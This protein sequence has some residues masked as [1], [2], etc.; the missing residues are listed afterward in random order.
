[1]IKEANRKRQTVITGIGIVS[2]LGIGL[3]DFEQALMSGKSGVKKLELLN[4]PAAP[5]SCG[6][7]VSAFIEKEARKT[8]LK[9]V[10]KSIK[11]MCR[12]IQLGVASALQAVGQSGLDLDKIES[13]RFG[14]DFGANLM[15]SPPQ[16]L[17]DS[18][19]ASSEEGNFV[20][21]NWGTIGLD[22]MEPLWLLCYL[23][24][25]PAC[26]IGISMD[27]QGPSN[28]IT[29]D[30]ASGYLVM[31]EAISIIDRDWADIM[32]AGATGTRLHI[33]KAIHG[34]FW[35][36]L[37]ESD[38]DPSTWSRP[39]DANRN[40]QV[41]AEGGASFILEEE[42]HAKARNAQTWGK[43]LGRGASCVNNVPTQGRY[44]ESLAAAMRAALR[45]AGL[46]PEEI[47][48]I[49]AHGLGEREADEGE[50]QAIHDV[51]GEHASTVPVTSMKS[52]WGNAGPAA[53]TLE[54]AASLVSLKHGVILPTLNYETP[55]TEKPLNVVHGEPLA[56]E[57]KIVL[58]INATRQGQAS[59]LIVE[60][61]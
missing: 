17:N 36:E 33:V 16:V 59:A 34:Q 45:D 25:M 32:I 55:G 49:N 24:N 38:E 56:T 58:A 42:E 46:Q 57:N 44:R 1:M 35:D 53:G 13:N 19:M 22:S 15:F 48:H 50:A 60:G 39:F 7:E 61:C 27:A 6:G 4:S 30:E 51:F 8:H 21:D 11:V 37:A 40:G 54:L 3:E 2:P 47:G 18:C 29:M 52:Y 5:R 10:R 12:E 41:L 31:G 23:P 43:I 26:H 20:F 9:P 14:V 28:S